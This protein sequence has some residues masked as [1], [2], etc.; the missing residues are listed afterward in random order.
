MQ[1]QRNKYLIYNMYGRTQVM[2]LLNA[3]WKEII[4]D[5]ITKLLKSKDFTMEILYDLMII[6]INR[7]TKYVHFVFFK[8]IFNI[9]QLRHLFFD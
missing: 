6:V 9:K 2:E 8:E 3:P 1:C 7:L 5:F 4:M